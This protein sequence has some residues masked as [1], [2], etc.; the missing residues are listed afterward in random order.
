MPAYVKISTAD[1]NTNITK[2]LRYTAGR[3]VVRAHTAPTLHM[4][5]SRC[6]ETLPGWDLLVASLAG[7][8]VW[9]LL[10]VW[11]RFAGQ[12]PSKTASKV[13]ICLLCRG[14]RGR[15][16]PSVYGRNP[17]RAFSSPPTPST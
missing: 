12:G 16:P 17:V 1:I 14:A 4:S 7:G 5:P 10:P 6:N 13:G 3:T 11:G 9:P 15:C 8:S 2:E